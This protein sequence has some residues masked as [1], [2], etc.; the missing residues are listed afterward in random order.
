MTGTNSESVP[1][2]KSSRKRRIIA[3][4]VIFFHVFGFIC[5][6]HAV[7][8]TRSAQAAIAWGISL[9]TIPYIAA[10]AYLIFGRNKFQG[11]V[12]ARQ[13]DTLETF[14]EA[15]RAGEEAHP[16]ISTIGDRHGSVRAVELLAKIP[17]LTHNDADLLIDGQATFDSIFQGIEQARDYILVQFYIVHDDRIGRELQQ[18]LM[19]KARAGVRIYFLYDEIGSFD[20]PNK[21]KEE[22]RAAGVAMH[23]FHTRKGPSNRFQINFRNHRKV[24]VVDGLAAWLGG[25]NVGDEYLG[26]DPN[27]GPW[28][29]THV[30]ITGPAVQ[31]VQVAFLEDYHWA[32]DDTLSLNW[33]PKPPDGGNKEI[34]IIPSGPADKLDTASLM[35]VHAIN[36]A[37]KRIWIASPYFVPDDAV[38]AALQLAGLRGVD[39]RI[40]VPEK[41]DIL[42]VYLAAFAYFDYTAKTG[43]KFYRYQKGFMHQKVMLVDDLVS[44]VGTVNF[45]N[46][47]FR[48]NFEITAMILDPGFAS[49]VEEM[50]ET[51]FKNAAPMQP[52]DYTN[53]PLWF[54][55]AVRFA[56]LLSPI[57]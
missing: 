38:M 33:K 30:K 29:D 24:V 23:N 19:A 12:T 39:V 20:L 57:L 22:L 42:L 45:D 1:K 35:Y 4:I 11:Y 2:R 49:R 47:A 16:F 13:S 10:P 27:I 3:G 25:H 40:L 21:Y 17:F 34:L 50:F 5:S 44:T 55:I 31:A 41:S 52:D 9:N 6:I 28:R 8:Y 43:V 15:R 18:R 53:K 32:T 36:S 7:L 26:R 48:L 46:R 56:R 14:E 54:K 51:D 37:K